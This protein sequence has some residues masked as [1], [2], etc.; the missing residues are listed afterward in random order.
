MQ[1]D[2]VISVDIK[3]YKRADERMCG[4]KEEIFLGLGGRLSVLAAE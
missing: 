2:E 1:A 3:E 4:E